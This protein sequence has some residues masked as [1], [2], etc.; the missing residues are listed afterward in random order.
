MISGFLTRLFGSRND[1]LLKTYQRNIERINALEPAISALDDESLRSKTAQ[2]RQRIAGGAR[3][4][5][6]PPSANQ[7]N[8]S[9]AAPRASSATKAQAA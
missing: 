8:V 1:R 6:G 7:P 4:P 3:R 2:F 5:A 9:A